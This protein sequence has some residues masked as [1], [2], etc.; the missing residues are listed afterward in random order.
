MINQT[1]ICDLCEREIDGDHFE[2]TY[3][4]VLM[5]D[6]NAEATFETG[7]LHIDIDCFDELRGPLR[8]DGNPQAEHRQALEEERQR[9]AEQRE[10]IA[11]EDEPDEAG[12]KK[13][14]TR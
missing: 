11:D 10:T 1:I 14:N 3:R 6:P 5:G 12:P 4:T 8:I 13:V 9:L 2:L 7:V